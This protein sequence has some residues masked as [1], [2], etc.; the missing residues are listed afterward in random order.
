VVGAYALA[1]A[2]AMTER[3]SPNRHAVAQRGWPLGD[4]QFSCQAFYLENR[5]TRPPHA[6]YWQPQR[7]TREPCIPPAAQKRSILR[8]CVLASLVEKRRTKNNH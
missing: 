5:R 3:L 4:A 7:T 6:N 2:R 8:A 1:A